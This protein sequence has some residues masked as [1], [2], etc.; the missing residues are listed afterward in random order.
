MRMQGKN[1]LVTGA[2][3]GIGRGIALAMAAEGAALAVT[4]VQRQEA[5]EQVV[6][7]I[8]D[9]GGAAFAVQGDVSR[10]D[11]CQRM[12]MAALERWRGRQ[13]SAVAKMPSD[14]PP[15]PR[16]GE[17]AAGRRGQRQRR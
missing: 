1:V 3:R 4:Y 16:S 13:T 12:I 7:S 14:E 6:A 9:A 15:A 10:S 11:D 17:V 2:G 8:I 5:A